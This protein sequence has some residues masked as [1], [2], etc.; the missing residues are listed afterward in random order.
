[1]KQMKQIYLLLIPLIWFCTSCTQWQRA[2]AVIAMADSLDVTQ[3]VIYDDTV[4]LRQTIRALNNPLGRTLKRN[5]LAKA[6]YYM[7]RNL[8]DDYK[9]IERAAECY[10]EADWLEINDPLYRGRVNSCM[11]GICSDYNQDTLSLLFCERAL[12]EFERSNNDWYYANCLLNMCVLKSGIKNFEEADSL[13][14][15][16]AS[17]SFDD[18][19]RWYLN[20]V[21]AIYF[22]YQNI[23]FSPDSIVYYLRK[24]PINDSY[25]ASTLSNAYYDLE[26][27]DSAVYYAWET[28]EKFK[29]K[30]RL[31]SLDK[32]NQI[33]AL[34]Q[35]LY[36]VKQK[37]PN[38]TFGVENKFDGLTLSLTYKN[39]VLQSIATRGNG[40]EG[41]N[42]TAQA[43]T[44]KSI[45]L[46]IKYQGEVS[47]QGEGLMLLSEL[48]K[49]NKTATE[50]LKNVRNAVSGALRNLDPKQTAKRNLSLFLY[51]ISYIEDR[52]ILSSQ[53][54]IESFLEQNGFVNKKSKFYN[55][56]EDVINRVIEIDAERDSYDY[57]TDGAVIKVN[58]FDIR[59]EMGATIKFPRWAIAYKYKPQEVSTLLTDVIWQVGKTGKITPTA[60][61]EP[62]ELA[63]AEVSRATLNNMGDIQRKQ[64]QCPSRVFIRRSNEVI[65]EITALASLVEDSKPIEAPKVCPSCS[66]NVVEIGALLYC[67]NPNCREQVVNKIA[68]F[69]SKDAMNIEHVSEKTITAMFDNLNVRNYADLYY[70]DKEALLSLEKFKEKKVAN[71]FEE[72]EKSKKVK[73][74]NF[75]YALCIANVGVKTAK[76]LSNQ[77]QT[78]ENLMSADK[79]PTLKIILPNGLSL[80][81]FRSSQE[82]YEK[83][84]SSEG[85]VNVN[86]VGKCKQNIWNGIAASLLW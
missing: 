40:F 42:V 38:A 78:L 22:Y 47:I 33:D 55:E 67:K 21:R 20:D 18:S 69:V 62:V 86:I 11:V 14:Q 13:W 75:L 10:I 48:E 30:E 63:G 45:P 61:V 7:G 49:Y 74:S 76:D 58:E 6:Y 37:Y 73:L 65:P 41:E 80:I 52:K 19:Y 77:Y 85:C 2:E 84:H 70:I 82:E 46:K 68:H 12:N 81:K 3:H 17:Y 26:Q 59:Q 36:D 16:A 9:Q 23:S 51:N 31:Y 32:V 4:A 35:W 56:I 72:I 44:I 50:V 64:V 28:I 25:R 79:N 34:R 8:E 60:I 43:I 29:H 83:L 66:G 54:D 71:Y 57:L 15:I 53:K 5:T 24:N 39:G 27:M 1:M